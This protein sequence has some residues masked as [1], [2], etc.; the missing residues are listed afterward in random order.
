MREWMNEVNPWALHRIAETLLEAAHRGLW[1]AQ[2]ETLAQLRELYL[3]MEGELEE[4][5]DG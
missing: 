1:R 3:S 4:R 2:E 5:A